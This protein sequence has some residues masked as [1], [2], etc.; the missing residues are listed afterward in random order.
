MKN[1]K[2]NVFKL[3]AAVVLVVLIA[4]TCR[5]TI[6][7]DPVVETVIDADGNEVA[8]AQLSFAEQYCAD[9]WDE[10]IVPT[11]KERAVEMAT[12][13]ADTNADLGA[14]GAKYGYR[15]NETSAWGFCVKAE[16]KVLE[17]ANADSKNKVQLVLDIAPYDGV[18][19][20]KVHFGKVFSTNVK[21]AI[22]D[23]VAFLKLDD[24]ANQV[25]FA[26]L[27]TAFN[28]RVKEGIFAAYAPEELV[29]KELSVCGCIS[30]TAPGLDNL[31]VIPVE[32]NVAGG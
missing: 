21:N 9:N 19:D 27:S 22:R 23:G 26:D 12:L 24:F 5:V 8:V 20:C 14:A 11:V 10:R 1:R 17:L 25:E 6:I 7:P 15:A 18:A 2:I 4:L 16:G 31:V 28:N 30:M 29:G 3:A 32:M 13:I